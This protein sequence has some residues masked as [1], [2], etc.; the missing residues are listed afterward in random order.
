LFAIGTNL[1]IWPCQSLIDQ[2]PLG[3]FDENIKELF[4]TSENNKY[5]YNKT[6]LPQCTDCKVLNWCR[7]GCRV[8]HLINMKAVDIACRIRQET[9][10]FILQETQNYNGCDCNHQQADNT[11]GDI[12]KDYLLSLAKSGVKP[13]F[14]ETPPLPE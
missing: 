2:Q 3:F 9:I 11:F 8:V 14:V 1:E 4:A 7:G 5:F 10:P 13:T 12:V 6:M